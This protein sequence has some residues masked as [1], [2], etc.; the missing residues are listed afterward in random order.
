MAIPHAVGMRGPVPWN[1]G[2]I[3]SCGRTSRG[4]CVASALRPGP[5]RRWPPSRYRCHALRCSP[6]PRPVGQPS[7]DVE[8]SL[9]GGIRSCSASAA[10]HQRILICRGSTLTAME[11][12]TKH[13]ESRVAGCLGLTGPEPPLFR[14]QTTADPTLIRQ[15]RLG[16]RHRRLPGPGLHQRLLPGACGPC[17]LLGQ[18]APAFFFP[19]RTEAD[20]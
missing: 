12:L 17:S 11:A 13:C 18:R 19:N 5:P 20:R 9:R 16:R 15:Q 6:S 4:S 10:V 8:V 14:R 1:A 2:P 3:R 7:T